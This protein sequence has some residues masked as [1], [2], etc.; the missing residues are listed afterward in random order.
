MGGRGGSRT[1]GSETIGAIGYS[2]EDQGRGG[3]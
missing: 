2:F 3:N 1:K